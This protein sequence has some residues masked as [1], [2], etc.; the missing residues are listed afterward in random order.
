ML[1]K[2]PINMLTH[3]CFS[4]SLAPFT[5]LLK[6]PWFVLIRGA[7]TQLAH[8]HVVILSESPFRFQNSKIA[9]PYPARK[10][11]NVRN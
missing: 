3:L 11:V 7:K 2:T 6:P 9:C 4:S 5:E 10:R 8:L 1:M